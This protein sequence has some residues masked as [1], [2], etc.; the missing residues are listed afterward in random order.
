[1]K[2]AMTLTVMVMLITLSIGA[3]AARFIRD[4]TVTNNP[5]VTDSATG[6]LWQGCAGGLSGDAC[7]TGT[8]TM[9]TWKNA[10][11]YCESLN[12]GGYTDWR[13]PNKKEL[14]SIVD[15]SRYNPARD[16]TAFP[17]TPSSDFWSS[18]SNASS[19]N[20]AWYVDFDYGSVYYYSKTD[21]YHARCVR[22]GL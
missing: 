6:L 3:W 1:M 15:D 18:S 20:S 7:A 9:Y 17:A 4:T 13:L 14:L 16:M 19:E 10:L 21:T 12:W 8:A 22:G 5:V 2:T 11:A